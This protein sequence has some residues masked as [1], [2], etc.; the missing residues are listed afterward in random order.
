MAS[1]VYY[2]K[3]VWTDSGLCDW[4]SIEPGSRHCSKAAHVSRG[5]RL[6]VA[7]LSSTSWAAL[8]SLWVLRHGGHPGRLP[9]ENVPRIGP[10]TLEGVCGQHRIKILSHVVSPLQMDETVS[11]HVSGLNALPVAAGWDHT[12]AVRAGGQLVCFGKNSNG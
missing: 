2:G 10:T 12:C 1:V 5:I 3:C 6:E 9:K 8:F 11:W 4:R 7:A